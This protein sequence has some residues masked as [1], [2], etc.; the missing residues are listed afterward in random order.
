[1][2][3]KNRS[4]NI[5][6]LSNLLNNAKCVKDYGAMG[7]GDVEY[8]WLFAKNNL[9]IGVCATSHYGGPL[10]VGGSYKV[11]RFN[12]QQQ[13]NRNYENVEHLLY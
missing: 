1:M 7:M 8:R 4:Q 2:E 5:E 9:L 10:L 12:N 11:Y 13:L 6:I 3:L